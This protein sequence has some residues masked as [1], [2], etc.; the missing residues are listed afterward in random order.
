M[1]NLDSK[2]WKRVLMFVSNVNVNDPMS[3]EEKEMIINISR[4]KIIESEA[5][6]KETN[7]NTNRAI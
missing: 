2:F 1:M 4:F 5:N 7:R 3:E 6:E